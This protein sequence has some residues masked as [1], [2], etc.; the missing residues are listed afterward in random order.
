VRKAETERR[1][2]VITEIYKNGN[3]KFLP[4]GD[5]QLAL[6]DRGFADEEINEILREAVIVGVV[7]IAI[8]VLYIRPKKVT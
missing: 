8:Y 7:V 2:R 5:V 3:H 1:F 4:K 6:R